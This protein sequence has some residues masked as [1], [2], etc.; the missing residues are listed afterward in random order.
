MTK[1]RKHY[2]PE[3]KVTILKR[4][5]VDKV[6]VADVCEEHG[7]NPTVFY[8]WQKQ[9]FEHGTVAFQRSDRRGEQAKDQRIAT[10]EAKLLQKNEV[11]AELMQEYV[12][13]KKELGEL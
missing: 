2:T 4:H 1:Q 5:L 6:P 13:L 11:V 8:T 3:Q 9:F 12:Q 10:L 7:L